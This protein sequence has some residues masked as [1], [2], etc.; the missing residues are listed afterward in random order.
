M[1]LFEQPFYHGTIRKAVI[2]F[3]QLFAGMEIERKDKDGNVIQAISVPIAYGP[4]EKWI[5]RLEEN[6]D[7]KKSISMELPRMAFE[8]MNYQYDPARK[9]GSNTVSFRPNDG[10]NVK[11]PT[12]IPY[13][14][15]INLYIAARTQ[16]DSLMIVEQILPFFAPG[17]VVEYDAILDPLV[18]TDMTFSLESVQI[19]DDWDGNFDEQR[20]ILHTLSFRCKLWLFG[21]IRT[22]K[23]IKRAIADISSTLGEVSSFE[24][25]TAEVNPFSAN[26]TDPHTIDEFYVQ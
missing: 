21:P 17:I 18:R 11:V 20:I 24:T 15:N 13:N 26:R 7:G 1:N 4:R 10:S 12:P 22:A 16:E 6:P 9:A 2:A 25:Y 8:I 23:V 19:Q 14:L 3:G 5:R